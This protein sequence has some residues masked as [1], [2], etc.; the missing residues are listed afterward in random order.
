MDLSFVFWNGGFFGGCFLR[1][2]D[3]TA[4]KSDLFRYHRIYTPLV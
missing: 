1:L 2:L 4:V 3:G